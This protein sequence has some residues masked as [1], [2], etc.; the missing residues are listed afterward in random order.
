MPAL[1]EAEQRELL[2]KVRGT[3]LR[4]QWLEN[5][6]RHPE[7]ATHGGFVRTAWSILK[8]NDKGPS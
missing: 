7:K 5:E 8:R 1:T 2:D 3:D 4:V 6:H